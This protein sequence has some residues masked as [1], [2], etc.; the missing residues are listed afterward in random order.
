MAPNSVVLDIIFAPLVMDLRL[1]S[2]VFPYVLPASGM[3]QESL[4]G[5]WHLIWVSV[6]KGGDETDKV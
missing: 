6:K 2:I 5:H 1:K 3:Y 4:P